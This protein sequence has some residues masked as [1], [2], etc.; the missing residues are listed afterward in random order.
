[1]NLTE[2]G[3]YHIYL[4]RYGDRANTPIIFLHGGPGDGCML[5]S[6]LAQTLSSRYHCICFDQM[7]CGRSEAIPAD[8]PFG[9]EQ[10][11]ALIETMRQE[12]G[13]GKVILY[14]HGYGGML[15]CLYANRY[16]DSVLGV[17]YDCPSFDFI[18]SVKSLARFLFQE[19]FIYKDRKSDGYRQCARILDT[20]YRQGDCA[21]V[22]DVQ[23][24]LQYIDNTG[25]RF[26]LHRKNAGCFTALLNSLVAEDDASRRKETVF[27]HKLLEDGMLCCGMQALLRQN[28]QP[29][30]LMVGKYD[31]ICSIEQRRAY[32]ENAENGELVVLEDSGSFPHLEEPEQYIYS[33]EEFISGIGYDGSHAY[34]PQGG[35]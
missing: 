24:L 30:L 13:L 32:I 6:D 25:I 33:V 29:S 21:C 10:H 12:L 2:I 34:R 8:V 27:L 7:G 17:V 20:P 16:P 35:Q 15:A 11:A 3:G 4:E 31:P 19:I 23:R 9:M 14:G 5:L 28:R 18:D 1:M 26:Y 22:E